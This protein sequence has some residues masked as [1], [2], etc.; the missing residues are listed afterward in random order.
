MKYIGHILLSVLFIDTAQLMLKSTVNN[1]I[2]GFDNI[3]S[4]VRQLL[5]NPLFI[6]AFIFIGL[7]ALIWLIT[8]SKVDLSYAYPMVAI[9]FVF[10]SIM[11]WVLFSESISPLRGFGIG[12]I[13]LG[14]ILMSRS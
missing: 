13:V 4:T 12:T 2:I 14:I 3:I 1:M 11:S 5:L 8:I 9:G 10:V 7:S 6:I